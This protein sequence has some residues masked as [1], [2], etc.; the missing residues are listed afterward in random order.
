MTVLGA[1]SRGMIP[2]DMEECNM[3]DRIVQINRTPVFTLWGAGAPEV[4]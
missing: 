2:V 4:I 3:A 1:P